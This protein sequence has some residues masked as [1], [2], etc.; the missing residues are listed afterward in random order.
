MRV[1]R[2]E[3]AKS[4]PNFKWTVRIKQGQIQLKKIDSSKVNYCHEYQCK[5][6]TLSFSLEMFLTV[7]VLVAES[8]AWE[9]GREDV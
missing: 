6:Y 1:P 2:R 4:I 8:P 3:A 9:G 5:V 7:T